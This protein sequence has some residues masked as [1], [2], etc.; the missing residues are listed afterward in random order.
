MSHLTVGSPLHLLA[1]PRTDRAK[2][3]AYANSRLIADV[4][5]RRYSTPS[6][7]QTPLGRPNARWE[8]AGRGRKWLRPSAWAIR[9]AFSLLG[10]SRCFSLPLAGADLTPPSGV[11]ITA[12]NVRVGQ[13][14][15]RLGRQYAEGL[16]VPQDRIGRARCSIWLA[17]LDDQTPGLLRSDDKTCDRR[18]AYCD[19]L[20]PSERMW[21]V[22]GMSCAVFGIDRGTVLELGPAWW[23]RY[24]ADDTVVLSRGGEETEQSLAGTGVLC[25][26]SNVVLFRHTEVATGLPAKS[27]RHFVEIVAW[28]PG[29]CGA[30]GK[31]VLTWRCYEVTGTALNVVAQQEMVEAGSIWPVPE[32][33]SAA[34]ARFEVLNSGIVAYEVQLDV[35]RRGQIP[36]ARSQSDR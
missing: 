16:G 6:R 21:A 13:I 5:L 4:R 7:P 35:T 10:P 22:R 11:R 12:S 27:A 19:A 15:R 25:P 28:R 14:R 33:Q 30:A 34:G 32:T 1:Q 36:A 9:L 8:A 29:C 24:Q 17:K 2:L 18:V 26:T 31:R 20:N 3:V 23:L